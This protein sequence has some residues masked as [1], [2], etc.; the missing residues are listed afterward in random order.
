VTD[1]E[2]KIPYQSR[3]DPLDVEVLDLASKH[4]EGEE[5]AVTEHLVWDAMTHPALK[6]VGDLLG[7]IEQASAEEGRAIASRIVWERSW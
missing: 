1:F 5:R 7:K 6:T 2:V 4:L 3:S